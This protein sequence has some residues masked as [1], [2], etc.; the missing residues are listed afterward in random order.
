MKSNKEIKENLSIEAE[1]PNKITLDE[2][3][4]NKLKVFK[5]IR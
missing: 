5:R 1:L 4:E 2:W 3:L